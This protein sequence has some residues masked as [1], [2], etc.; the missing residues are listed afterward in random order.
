MRVFELRHSPSSSLHWMGLVAKDGL[1]CPTWLTAET[2]NSWLEP[3]FSPVSVNFLS[4]SFSSAPIRVKLSR[5]INRDSRTYSVTSA[6][7]SYFGGLQ[8]TE[9]E[10]LVTAVTIKSSGRSGTA[11]GDTNM[12]RCIKEHF[13]CDHFLS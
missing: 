13:L 2:L 8:A 12:M 7:P 11:G 5:P 9:M 10:S 4:I 1:P 3:S 6:P